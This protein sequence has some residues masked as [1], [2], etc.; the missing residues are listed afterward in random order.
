MSFLYGYHGST[1]DKEWLQDRELSKSV[2]C[3]QIIAFP[4][5]T[6]QV[7]MQMV[8]ERQTS[9]ISQ[10]P[11]RKA[12][13]QLTRSTCVLGLVLMYSLSYTVITS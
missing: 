13:V 3:V 4:L 7:C 9:G 2:T 12:L 10:Y 6:L 5:D 1:S 11:L 8:M